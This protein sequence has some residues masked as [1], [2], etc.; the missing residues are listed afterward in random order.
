[1]TII[2]IFR[3][4]L[5]IIF[6]IS[7]LFLV[8]SLLILAI[9]KKLFDTNVRHIEKFGDI[10]KNNSFSPNVMFDLFLMV[11]LFYKLPT[12]IQRPDIYKYQKMKEIKKTIEWYSKLV[13][14][15]AWIFGITTVTLVIYLNIIER[16]KLQ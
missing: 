4:V 2:E 6:L 1:M 5:G 13:K 12:E 8:P 7:V 16:I 15:V 10:I 3:N 14:L 9:N 11:N